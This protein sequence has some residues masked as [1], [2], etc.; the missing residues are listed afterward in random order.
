MYKYNIK[1]FRQAY[2]FTQAE[3]AERVGCDQPMVARWENIESTS[4]VTI[5]RENIDKLAQALKVTASDIDCTIKMTLEELIQQAKADGT[6][7]AKNCNKND[8][9]VL[10]LKI[11]QDISSHNR[12]DVCCD[13][14]QLS[15]TA[16]HECLFFYDLLKEKKFTSKFLTIVSAFVNG[17]NAKN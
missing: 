4:N 9:A 12:D 16:N 17:L 2:G 3:L 5:S 15:A 10:K 1:D 11:S 14:L 13:I 8:L 6:Y 7:I